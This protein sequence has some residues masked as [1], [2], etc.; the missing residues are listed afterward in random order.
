LTTP[1]LI[2]WP[3]RD[4]FGSPEQGEALVATVPNLRVV[5]LPG[6]G[7]LPWIDDPATVIAEI[8]RFL[9]TERRRGMDAVA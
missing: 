6:L 1:T 2:L 4:A 9:T 3:E 5:R 7:H 8:E